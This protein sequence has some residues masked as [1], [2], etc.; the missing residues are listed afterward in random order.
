MTCP[1]EAVCWLLEYN[2][3]D[4]CQRAGQ[5]QDPPDTEEDEE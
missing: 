3:Y 4:T 1:G 5:C 2:G